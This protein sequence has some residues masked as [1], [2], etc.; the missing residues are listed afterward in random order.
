MIEVE[1]RERAAPRPCSM[2]RL[3]GQCPFIFIG[4]LPALPTTTQPKRAPDNQTVS[5]SVRDQ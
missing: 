1:P 2:V 5:T 3:T 4:A